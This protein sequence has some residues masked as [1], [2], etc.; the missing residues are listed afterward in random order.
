MTP[1]L[2][3]VLEILSYYGGVLCVV[4][5]TIHEWSLQE[6]NSRLYG[7]TRKN[8]TSPRLVPR[9]TQLGGTATGGSTLP[10]ASQAFTTRVAR[11][12]GYWP[13]LFST[14]ILEYL[15]FRHRYVRSIFSFLVCLQLDQ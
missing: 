5:A 15:H 1:I 14:H 12:R 3:Q 9:C 10:S 2:K 8:L 11:E 7:T 6:E 13:R 4:S